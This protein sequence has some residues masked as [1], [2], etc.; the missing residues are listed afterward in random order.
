MKILYDKARAPNPRRVRIFLAE[1]GLEIPSEQ[2]DLGTLEHKSEAFAAINPLQRLPVL[3][4]DDGQA[5]TESIAICRYF[6]ALHPQPP[7]FGIGAREQA[8]V[9][10]WQRRVELNLLA[11]IQNV[12]RH[13]HPAMKPMEPVQIA[14]WS[15][16]NRPKIGEFLAIMDSQLGKTRFVAGDNFSVADITAMIAVDFLKPIKMSVP[17]EMPNVLRWHAEVSARPSAKA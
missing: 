11:A 14:E 17:P 15:E 1:K 8:F 2:V 16:V 7:L 12:F 6:E 9:E 10:M 5:L 3:I 4:L 13:S